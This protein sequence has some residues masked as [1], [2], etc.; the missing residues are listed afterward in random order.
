MVPERPGC[1]QFAPP[2]TICSACIGAPA[3]AS[4]ANA[5]ALAS[6]ASAVAEP[7]QCRPMPLPDAKPWRMPAAAMNW[8]CG[9]SPLK[10]CPTSNSA[11][12][13][14]PRS[15][16]ACAAATRP[17]SRLG[18]MS[19][20]SDA[21]G[22]AS[23]SSACPPPN[24]SACRLGDERPGHRLDHAARGERALGAAGAQLHRREDRLARRVAALER[25]HRHLVDADDAHDL[26]D[27]VGLALHV[28]APRRHRDLHHRAAGRPS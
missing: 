23:A 3:A 14:K 8:S 22:L 27:D 19:D 9:L 18:R 15:L 5:S 2:G 20:R 11:T 4:T 24:S 12:S 17:G 10:I 16:L 1:S 28:G 25:R 7:D 21:I 6:S 13:E 26:L